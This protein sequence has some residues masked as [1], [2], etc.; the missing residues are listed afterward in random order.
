MDA[1]SMMIP[2]ESPRASPP[3]SQSHGLKAAGGSQRDE[4]LSESQPEEVPQ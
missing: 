2:N 1:P 4:S 3:S